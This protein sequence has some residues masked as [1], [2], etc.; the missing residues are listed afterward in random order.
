MLTWLGC[1]VE[2]GS[3]DERNAGRACRR[4]GEVLPAAGRQTSLSAAGLCQLDGYLDGLARKTGTLVLFDL[5][6][7]PSPPSSVS[8][9]RTA[10]RPRGERCG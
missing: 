10:Q 2:F 4:C 6:P 7:E 3:R 8:I 9:S 5:R 1:R